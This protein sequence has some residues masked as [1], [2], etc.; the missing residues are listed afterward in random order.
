MLM[1]LQKYTTLIPCAHTPSALNNLVSCEV[2]CGHENRTQNAWQVNGQ[3]SIFFHLS[4]T[5]TIG[6]KKFESCQQEFE[7]RELG[8]KRMDVSYCSRSCKFP[9]KK[10]RREFEFDRAGGFALLGDPFNQG[11]GKLSGICIIV[12]DARRL[13]LLS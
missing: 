9:D 1:N 12:F 4:E 11:S 8:K 5:N 7:F 2:D 10:S 3:W 6:R 13:I